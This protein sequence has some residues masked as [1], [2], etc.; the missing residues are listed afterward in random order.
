MNRRTFIHT[1]AV[2]SLSQRIDAES[3]SPKIKAG[4]LGAA[5]SH[6][7][8]KIR[9]LQQSADFELVGITEP[10]EAVRKNFPNVRWLSQNELFAS[11]QVIFVES[12]VREHARHAL[13]VL[14]AGKHVHVEKPPAA[15]WHEMEKIIAVAREKNLLL[16]SGYMW[17]YHPGFEAIFEAA[18]QGW[19]GEIYQ[20]RT[21]MMNQLAA[22]RREEWAEFKG[23]VFF[24]Q[25]SHLVDAVVR[26]L[27]R[28]K[29]VTPF[30]RSRMNDALVD[31]NVAVFEFDR[32]LATITNSSYQPNS[33]AHRSFEAL[34]TNGTITLKP[35]EP[36]VLE[37]DLSKA[38]GPYKA[39]K[40]AVPLPEYK[41]YVGDIADMAQAVRGGTLRASLD[42]ELLVH[43]WV[44]K[45]SAMWD[46]P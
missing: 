17:R 19:L 24:E 44:L 27:G 5:H 41:R 21:A 39:G 7:A 16:Q 31:N 35:I 28:P 3:Q 46:R 29:A 14:R 2:A 8:G 32:A 1:M 30:L 40:Q 36:P 37:L 15:T 22:N 34:G 18:R 13:A 23:G 12:D 6:A 25:A 45:A 20:V 43:E 4:V 33:S 11:A 10:A 9:L 38:A 42:E 26:L